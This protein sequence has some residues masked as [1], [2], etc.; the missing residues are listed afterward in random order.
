MANYLY[1]GVYIEEIPAGAKPIEGVSTS[2]AAFVGEAG[3][4]PV[5]EAN[6]IGR[7]DGYVKDHGGIVSEDD[8]MGLAVQAFYLNGGGAAY[9][10]RIAGEGS[11]S[12]VVSFD[13]EGGAGV[14][15]TTDPVLT[16]TATS[17]GDW[18]NDLYV[19]IIKPAQDSLT[20]DLLIGHRNDGEFVEDE[21]FTD[22]TMV[23]GDDNYALRQVNGNSLLV[24][25]S[26]GIAADPA[27]ASEMYQAAVVT[28][29]TISG[30]SYLNGLDSVMVLTLN[31]NDKGA[32]QIILNPVDIDLTEDDVGSDGEAVAAAIQAQVNTIDDDLVYTSFTCT[33][34]GSRFVLTS[35]EDESS[36]AIVIY[37]GELASLLRLS[38]ADTAVLTSAQVDADEDLFSNV[39]GGLPS[40]ADAGLTLNIDNLGDIDITLNIA[41]MSLSG[42]NETDG[43]TVALAI[44]NGVRAVNA[45][46]PSYKDF[47]CDYSDTRNFVLTSGSNDVRVSNLAVTDGELA[48]FLG[49]NDADNPSLVLGRQREQGT[50]AVIPLQSLGAL[51]SLGVQLVGGNANAPTAA[52]YSAFYNTLLRKIRD[53]SIVLLPG[54]AWPS[55][56]PH[57]VI[58]ATLAHCES[59]GNRILI[60]DPPQNM[61]LEQAADVTGLG[62]PTSTYS[63][64]YYPWVDVAN[65]FYHEDSNPNAS[66]TLTI[67][68][69]AFAAG[70]WAKTDGRRGVWKAPA[71][72]ETQLNGAAALEFNVEDLEQGQLNPLGINC[73]RNVPGYGSVIWGSRTLATRASPEWRY[74]PVR[75]TA[76]FIEQS[77]FNGIQ[78]AVFEPNDHPLWGSLRG[79]IGSFMNG[80][81]RSGAFQG[82]TANDA[83]FVRCG[84]GDTMTQGDI[85][86]GQVIVIV[87]FAPVKPAEFVIVRIQQKVG[88]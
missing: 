52:D 73:Y 16:I 72:V 60:V 81:F 70:M 19:K 10:C 75:R 21:A 87:G 37:D 30:G 45:A 63:T 25:L 80:L 12:A 54:E 56:G 2:V 33:F 20:F 61:E 49:L 65:P 48:D 82:K 86:R 36:A 28:S 3:R 76:I 18:G 34:D 6:L 31:I 23:A 83:Y 5:G 41:E 22:L 8:A 88:Q 53:V 85:D 7:F 51:A 66:T 40:I 38:S 71:G 67:A 4:G 29:G 24:V 44:Q 79:N 17:E 26:L 42:V 69:S 32:E 74:V 62:L 27:N 39:P 58:D 46:I 43:N 77:I 55:S 35:I 14:G 11:T 68:P 9:I 15:D 57:A 50:S 64:L 78:W 84:L 59:M 1:P 13:G 47:S